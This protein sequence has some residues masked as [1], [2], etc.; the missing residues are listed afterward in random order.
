MLARGARGR[1]RAVSEQVNSKLA[2]ALVKAQ[3][4]AHA[5]EKD[6]ANQHHRYK[7]ASAESMIREAKACLAECGLSFS[8]ESVTLDKFDEHLILHVVYR[9]RHESGE[10]EVHDRIQ[11]IIPGAGRPLDKA[12]STADTYALGYAMRGLLALPR[13]EEGTD[14]DQRDDRAA[15]GKKTKPAQTKPKPSGPSDAELAQ[16]DKISRALADAQDGDMLA[17]I[18][19]RMGDESDAVRAGV[20]GAYAEA[21]KRIGG[22]GHAANR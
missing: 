10:S 17:A 18:A 2:S 12:I 15:G 14:V 11:A 19:A 20:R 3:A 13:V 4:M 9:L 5:V 22:G 21:K 16:I 8:A 1:G 6:S 7:Y